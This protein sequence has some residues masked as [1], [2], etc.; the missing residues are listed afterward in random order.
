MWN[1]VVHTRRQS[2]DQRRR[3]GRAMAS[4][5]DSSAQ[6]DLPLALTLC[7]LY[8]EQLNI[9]GDRGN[10]LTFQQRCRWRSIALR[11]VTCGLGDALDPAA[12]DLLFIGGG[13]DKEQEEVARDLR[14][15]KAA[16][17]RIGVEG[18]LPGV[19]VCGG[20]Q[21]FAPFFRPA[22]GT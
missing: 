4:L 8:P 19:A 10:I 12:Y 15:R 18:G 2:S 20:Y 17:V 7:H 14:E 13:Q 3:K 6:G 16:A 11:I 1:Q 9:Y 21:L 5:T 22:P